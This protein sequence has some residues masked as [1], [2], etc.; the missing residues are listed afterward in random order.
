VDIGGHPP[1]PLTRKIVF[2]LGSF[3][4][5]FRV[6]NL[7]GRSE[8]LNDVFWGFGAEVTTKGTNLGLSKFFV[9][10]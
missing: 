9:L 6:L 7:W 4:I 10:I 3:S 8:S 5:V 2:H 1:I